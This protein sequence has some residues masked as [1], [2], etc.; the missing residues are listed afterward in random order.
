MKKE[1]EERGEERRDESGS[2]ENG[3]RR[4]EQGV[5]KEG[6]EGRIKVVEVETDWVAVKRRTRQRSQQQRDEESVKSSRRKFNGIQIV[7]KVDNSKTCMIDATP[8]DEVSNIMRKIPNSACCNKRDVHVTF[9]GRVLKRI[10]EV[11]TS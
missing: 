6:E 9:E 10:D 8:S 11:K 2:K 4:E 3:G 5:R 7:V 1:K